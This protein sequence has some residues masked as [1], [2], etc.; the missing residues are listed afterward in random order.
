[1]LKYLRI[2][3]TAICLT[4]CV[5][6]VALWVRSMRTR[7]L[8]SLGNVNAAST[9]GRMVLFTLPNG[10]GPW[11]LDD[12]PSYAAVKTSKLGQPIA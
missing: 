4:A 8:A 1:M 10:G 6:L 2:A 3:V 5:L 7:D 11:R 12:F 9:Q